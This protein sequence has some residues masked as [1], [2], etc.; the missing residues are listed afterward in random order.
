MNQIKTPVIRSF[1]QAEQLTRLTRNKVPIKNIQ[2]R[3]MSENRK[4]NPNLTAAQLAVLKDGYTER[5]NTG[6]YLNNKDTGIYHCANCD[7][8]LYKSDTKF[9]SGCGWPS[10]YEEVSPNALRR[11]TDNSGGMER[12]EIRC[13]NCDGHLG[14]VFEN[15]GWKENLGLP[16]DVRYCVNSLSLNF[17]K[18]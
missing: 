13:G 17:K 1:L 11:I 3:R 7:S 16:K 6:A 9:D 8:P 10:F 2:Y 5:P 12:T 18:N 4:W 14:H 15:E